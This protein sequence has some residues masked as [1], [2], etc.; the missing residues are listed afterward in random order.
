MLWQKEEVLPP[1]NP[2]AVLACF[3]ATKASAPGADNWLPSELS[4]VPWAA[5][6]AL[7]QLFEM[8]EAG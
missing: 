3:R 1:L 2:R 5:A 6:R 4:N 7:C 8:V